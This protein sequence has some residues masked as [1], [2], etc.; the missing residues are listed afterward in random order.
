ML[1]G[2]PLAE[3]DYAIRQ[4]YCINVFTDILVHNIG[5]KVTENRDI[6]YKQWHIRYSILFNLSHD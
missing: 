1:V 2:K 3:N 4:V 5:Y 6:L